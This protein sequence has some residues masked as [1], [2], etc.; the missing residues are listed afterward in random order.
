[1]NAFMNRY[2]RR[3][4]WEIEAELLTP[5][6][7]GGADQKAEWRAAPFKALLRYW[8]RLT[9][10]PGVS[11]ETLLKEEARIFGSAGEQEG[12]GG[13]SLVRV[14]IVSRSVPQTSA[15]KT[16]FKIPYPKFQDGVEALLYLAGMGL[17]E[18]NCQ[19]KQSRSYFPAESCVTIMVDCCREEEAELQ[20]ALALIQA[21]GA[22]GSR[23]RN[24]WGSFCLT[25]GGL[26]KEEALRLLNLFT[27]P[28]EEG[29]KQDYPN[30][31]GKDDRGPLLWK[32]QKPQ[33]SWEQAMRD[34]ADAYVGVRAG[35][36]GGLGTLDADG[37]DHPS[38]R[39]LLGFPLTHHEARRH[40][41][42]G[43]DGR[44]ASPLR[45]V[46][47]RRSEGFIGFVLHLPHRFSDDMTRDI[48]ALQK[49]KQ[50]EVW[51]KVHRKLDH[52]LQRAGYEECL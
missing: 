25:S 37:T 30:C 41:G 8:W 49:D 34:L 50:L 29:F 42:W 32:T 22:L 5:L 13:Q 9:R 39:H 2:F 31:L 3:K 18:P 46:V 28:W 11:W 52:L 36:A 21:F 27:H 4:S 23:C 15:L 24:G 51:G 43:R 38:E 35:D 12:K 16:G 1:M 19:V 45:F 26:A 14:G 10:G 48:A 6:F 47:R 7:L 40:S 33:K 20:K 44:H 17:L